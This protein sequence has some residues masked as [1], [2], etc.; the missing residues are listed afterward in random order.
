MKA[1]LSQRE[2]LTLCSTGL[3]GL[4]LPLNLL[5]RLDATHGTGRAHQLLG[6][7]Q[8]D[9]YPLYKMPSKQSE[10]LSELGIDQIHRITG[11]TVGKDDLSANRVWYELDGTGYAHSRRIQPVRM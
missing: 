1:P 8:I 2:F 7:V 6:R 11:I 5:P 3:A 4:L 9:Q 10:V